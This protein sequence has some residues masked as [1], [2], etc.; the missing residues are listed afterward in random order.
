METSAKVFGFIFATFIISLIP[1]SIIYFGY[2][3]VIDAVGYSQYSIPSYW[4]GYV[5]FIVIRL[6]TR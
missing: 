3:F 2:N 5:A 6:I 4:V 1:Y